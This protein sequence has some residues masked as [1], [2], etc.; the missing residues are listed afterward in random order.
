MLRSTFLIA[1]LALAACGDNIV[2]PAPPFPESCP[3]GD[4]PNDRTVTLWIQDDPD[5]GAADAL[6]G[7]DEWQPKCLK[8][9][10]TDDPKAAAQ[11]AVSHEACKPK[12][13]GSYVLAF[14]VPGGRVTIMMECMRGLF[15]PEPDGSVSHHVLT[16][17]IAHELGHEA[18]M[19]W[20]VPAKC[21]DAY[22]TNDFEKDLVTMGVC[23]TAVMNPYLNVG[24]AAITPIDGE[25]F[26]LRDTAHTTFP[27]FRAT[28]SPTGCVLTYRP[29][30]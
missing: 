29:A 8:C 13:D 23:G 26:D 22:A 28:E 14:S 7:C 24:L 2:P 21:D 16:Q 11:L 18:G 9:Q 17:V 15:S 20:H 1:F 4:D 10:I 19:W 27:R 6:A 3:S 25:A 5:L 30:P 12:S